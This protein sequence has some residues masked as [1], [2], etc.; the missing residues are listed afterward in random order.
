MSITNKKFLI[1]FG[2]AQAILH[3]HSKTLLTFTIIEKQGKPVNESE[4]VAIELT[5]LR[6]DLY[7]AT[8]TEKNGNTVTQIQ[9]H[10]NGVVYNNWTWPTG[11]FKHAK[12]TLKPYKQ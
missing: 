11:E 10:E 6:P 12:G 2:M 3:L 5:E 9:D 8:W 1:D 4:T 7:M